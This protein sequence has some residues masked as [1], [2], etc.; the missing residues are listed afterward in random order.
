MIEFV[1][2]ILILLAVYLVISFLQELYSKFDHCHLPDTLLHEKAEIVDIKCER[3]QYINNGAKFKTNVIFSDGFVFTT[4]RTNREG[5]DWRTYK[6]SI[7]SELAASICK[8][9]T[10]A[11][12][13]AYLKQF[14]RG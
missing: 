2:I 13:K 11:H 12:D 7:D 3:V 1:N 9:A 4:Y 6:I 8:K 5:N 14:S 10:I